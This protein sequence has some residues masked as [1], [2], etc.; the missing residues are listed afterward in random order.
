[1]IRVKVR[2]F[3]QAIPENTE[4]GL[5][6]ESSVEILLSFLRDKVCCEGVRSAGRKIA[7]LNDTGHMVVLLNGQSIFSFSGWKTPLHD[8]DE[9]S[10]MPMA[11]GG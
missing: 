6:D 1:M 5:E 7:F 2:I 4:V 3:S 8:G 10:L 11:A 9:I